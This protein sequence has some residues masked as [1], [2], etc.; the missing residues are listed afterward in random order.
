[1]F[2][3]NLEELGLLAANPSTMI[4][5]Q[6]SNILGHF[7][8]DVKCIMI[9][10]TNKFMLSKVEPLPCSLLT[11]TAHVEFTMEIVGQGLN[12]PLFNM[13]IIKDSIGVYTE[14]LLDPIS[15]PPIFKEL[16]LD[17]DQKFIQVL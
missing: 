16:A 4:L 2:I 12:L 11:S 1:M 15:R 14:W 3:S 8:L 7:P 13:P 17:S 5:I 9:S 6:D 10:Q